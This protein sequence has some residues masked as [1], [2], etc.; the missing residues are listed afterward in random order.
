M[1]ICLVV[2]V[3]KWTR[4]PLQAKEQNY[5]K[6]AKTRQRRLAKRENSLRPIRKI[7]K[8]KVKLPI[9]IL[10]TSCVFFYE[11]AFLCPG[12]LYIEHSKDPKIPS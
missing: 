8:E 9:L 6:R 2:E 5:L 7:L 12:S 10:L 4:M 11:Y 1:I 3:L